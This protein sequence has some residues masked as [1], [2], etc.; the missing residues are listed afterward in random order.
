MGA[1]ASG[2]DRDLSPPKRCRS[3][4]TSWSCLP[5]F[6]T[7]SAV[8]GMAGLFLRRENFRQK[9]QNARPN[10]SARPFAFQNG[11]VSTCE[12]IRRYAS[13]IA[14]RCSIVSPARGSANKRSIVSKSASADPGCLFSCAVSADAAIRCSSTTVLACSSRSSHSTRAR[15]SSSTYSSIGLRTSDGSGPG[16]AVE[17][18]FRRPACACARTESGRP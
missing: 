4:G 2:N 14:S 12:S 17:R 3:Y 13:L 15:R 16:G 18:A 5:G 6:W 10:K 7:G 9:C 11:G 8:A 1:A